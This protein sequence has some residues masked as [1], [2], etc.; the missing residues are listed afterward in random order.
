MLGQS[1]GRHPLVRCLRTAHTM[2]AA[3]AAVQHNQITPI[4]SISFEN[5]MV[6][7]TVRNFHLPLWTS[8][9]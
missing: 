5:A 4:V 2:S 8:T 7:G 6:K 3:A 1:L 9:R